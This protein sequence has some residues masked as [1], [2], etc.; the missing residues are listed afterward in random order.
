MRWKGEKKGKLM[1]QCNS[2]PIFASSLQLFKQKYK[3]N[4]P[5]FLQSKHWKQSLYSNS[6][7]YVS[8]EQRILNKSNE[9]QTEELL[10]PK[11]TQKG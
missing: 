8:V 4:A 9:I 5:M 10:L 11:V 7:H 2:E 6:L 1:T 3:I